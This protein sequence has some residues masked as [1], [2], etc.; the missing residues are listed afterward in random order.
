MVRKLSELV[1]LVS[2]NP[3][4]HSPDINQATHSKPLNPVWG[5]ELLG[6]LPRVWQ[7]VQE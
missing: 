1:V 3:H 6:V 4:I 5:V 7:W 2:C